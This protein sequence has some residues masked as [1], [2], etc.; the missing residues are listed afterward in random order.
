MNKITNCSKGAC[1]TCAYQ[2]DIIFCPHGCPEC[3]FKP[4]GYRHLSNKKNKTGSI[5][6]GVDEDHV[7]QP[8]WYKRIYI[9]RTWYRWLSYLF[10]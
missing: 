7:R 5:P 2:D 6:L 10:S 1:S 3:E 4:T 9:I 8:S